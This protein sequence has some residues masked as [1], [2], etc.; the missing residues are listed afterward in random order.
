MFVFLPRLFVFGESLLVI[1]GEGEAVNKMTRRVVFNDNELEKMEKE[2]ALKNEI[3][4]IKSFLGF[5]RGL[6]VVGLVGI[7]FFAGDFPLIT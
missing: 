4:N 3:M 5:F 2:L 7:F 6:S 1:V